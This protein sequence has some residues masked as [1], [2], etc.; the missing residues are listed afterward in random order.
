SIGVLT[1]VDI[2]WP[3]AEDPLAAGQTISR[4]LA[5][6]PRVKTLFYAVLP[7]C[8]ALAEGGKRLQAEDLATLQELAALPVHELERLLRSFD[9]FVKGAAPSITVSSGARQRVLE[10]LGLYG[11]HLACR[12][13]RDG[14]A[15]P[16]ELSD[17]ILQRSGIP[18]LVDQLRS[19]FG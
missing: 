12:L 7:I 8:A 9:R 10:R 14:A 15:S 1:K 18:V 16:T 19:H 2:Y 5:D 6:D 17:L 3:S 4:R 13:L 11:V